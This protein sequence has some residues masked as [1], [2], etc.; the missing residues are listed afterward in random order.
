MEMVSRVHGPKENSHSRLD[1]HGLLNSLFSL[2]GPC[3]RIH[4]QVSTQTAGKPKASWPSVSSGKTPDHPTLVNR[5]FWKRLS[6]QHHR[7]P[8]RGPLEGLLRA[9][10]REAF[11]TV[12]L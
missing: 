6:R 8:E 11:V 10:S 2:P 9:L 12:Y 5:K 4:T 7:K 1:V 3:I